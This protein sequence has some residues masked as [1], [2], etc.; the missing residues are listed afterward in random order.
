MISLRDVH[1]VYHTRHGNKVVL[2]GVGFDLKMGEKLGVLGRN[3]A[4]KST[5]IRLISGAELPTSGT[6]ERHMSVSWPL[7]FG[8]AFQ[9]TLTGIDNI[10]FISR[11]YNQDFERNLAFVEDFAE[12]GPYLREPV[13]TY[14]S[15]MR[16]RLAFA[17]SMII[18]FDCFLIDEVGAVGDARFH[19]RC[20]FELF[21][22]RADRA[23]IIISHDA[24]YIREHCDRWAVLHNAKLT[25]YDDFELAYGD[26]RIQIGLDPQPV[27]DQRPVTSRRALVET[28]QHRSLQD[29]RFMMLAREGD[30]RRDAGQWSLSEE[31]YAAA[32]A[33]YPYERSRWGQHGHVTRANGLHARAEA[34]YRTA[35]ALGVPV[36]DVHDFW[37]FTMA[38]QSVDPQRW[39][40]RGYVA[41]PASSQVPGRPDVELFARILWCEDRTDDGDIVDLLRNN[42]TCDEL[43]SAMLQDQRF[44]A[45]HP[46]WPKIVRTDQ[47]P[48][49]P[50]D[51]PRALPQADAP[52]GDEEESV[53]GWIRDICV[54]A[55][56]ESEQDETQ[57]SLSKIRTMENAWPILA[58]AGAFSDWPLTQSFLRDMAGSQTESRSQA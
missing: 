47:N 28:S 49:R 19:A 16:A 26:F 2:D 31:S 17:I 5:L 35:C 22:K 6:I 48:V 45:A 41:G 40:L 14:S 32:L 27:D 54:I 3:G 38:G 7:A 53:A 10:R 43:L 20:N 24:A 42:A 23:M 1:K 8:G 36:Q 58:S 55:L 56:P 37:V 18:E 15:G 34:S 9:A 51:G 39:P 29:E 50:S 12:L 57:I 30:W 52:D 25:L 13:R 21:Q 46:G 4:G 44:D 11:I 33:L